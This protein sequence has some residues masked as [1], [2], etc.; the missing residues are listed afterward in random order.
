[1]S[2]VTVT[3]G[4]GKAFV[5]AVLSQDAASI[6]SQEAEIARRVRLEV[7]RLRAEAEADARK[8]GEAQA[9]AALAPDAAALKTALAVL[10]ETW[11]QLAAPLAQKEQELAGLVTELSFLLAQH[12]TGVE[13]AAN[14]ASLQKL[15]ERLIAEAAAERG[16][17]QTLLIRLNPENHAQLSALIPP[18]TATLLA[19]DTVAPGGAL[20]EISAP[21]GDPMDKIEWDAS[22]SGRLDAIRT[23]L[24][25]PGS[26]SP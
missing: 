6:A 18:E 3:R 11:A 7:S 22:L 9:R 2:F 23:A 1:M 17:R 16:P 26:A 24:A 14:P 19:D 25:L 21:D 13:A 5:Q 20:V 15:V 4:R 8:Q 10:H 12:I